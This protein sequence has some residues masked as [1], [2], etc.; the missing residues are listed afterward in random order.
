MIGGFPPNRLH[1]RTG[2]FTPPGITLR[3][4]ANALMERGPGTAAVVLGMPGCASVASFRKRYVNE[5]GECRSRAVSLLVS[6]H[7]A[8]AFTASSCPIKHISGGHCVRCED[9]LEVTLYPGG[10]LVHLSSCQEGQ[11]AHG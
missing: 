10:L 7:Q 8:E 4:S 2:E 11:S 6:L 5:L 3:A 9:F 1:A